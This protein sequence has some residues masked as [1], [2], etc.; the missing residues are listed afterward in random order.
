MSGKEMMRNGI[1]GNQ[2]HTKYLSSSTP[3]LDP[4]ST[5]PRYAGEKD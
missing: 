3:Y 1:L 5:S 4:V 2:S